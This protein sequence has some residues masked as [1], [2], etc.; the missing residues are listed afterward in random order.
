MIEYKIPKIVHQTFINAKLPPEIVKIVQNNKNICKGCK[1]Y[2]Y[3]DDAC[4]IFIRKHFDSRVYDAFAKINP[5]YGAMKADFFRYC[6]LYVKGGVYLDI[7]TIMI[8]P[9]FDFLSEYDTCILGGLD[10]K[11]EPWRNPR[12]DLGTWEQWFL[13]FAPGHLYLKK[14]IDFMVEKIHA[15]WIPQITKNGYPLTNMKQKILHITGPDAFSH[16]IKECIRENGT[17]LH[18]MIPYVRWNIVCY[19]VNEKIK[20][21]MYKIHGKKH[22]SLYNEPLFLK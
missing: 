22:Y 2:F 11:S 16:V 5:V 19:S 10:H 4:D 13:V 20:Q 12:Y 1:F 14:M 7:K 3:D 9:I 15:Q 17:V 21:K 8:K 6:V 18:R